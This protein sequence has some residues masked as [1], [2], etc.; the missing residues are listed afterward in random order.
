MDDQTTTNIDIGSSSFIRYDPTRIDYTVNDS[1]LKSLA[2]SS[3]NLWKDVC[4]VSISIGIPCIINAVADTKNPFS[5]TFPLFLNYLFGILGILL[6]IIFFIAWRKTLNTLKDVIN[7]IKNKPMMAVKS[8][9]TE[10]TAKLVRPDS[11]SNEE[12]QPD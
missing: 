8:G 4:L 12:N 9:S 2:D 6:G 1:E 10:G 11:G 5:L 7:R 3:Q